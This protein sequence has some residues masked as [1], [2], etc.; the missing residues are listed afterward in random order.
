MDTK[1]KKSRMILDS[2]VSYLYGLGGRDFEM[3]I[4]KLDSFYKISVRTTLDHISNDEWEVL[5]TELNY[6]R[7]MEVEQNYWEISGECDAIENLALIGMM[8]DNVDI[9]FDGCTLEINIL[10]K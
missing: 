5:N 1:F 9:S 2:L 7:H 3:S 10:R 8:I 4:K 6:P